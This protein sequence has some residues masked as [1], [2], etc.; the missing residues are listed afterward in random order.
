MAIW[1]DVDNRFRR[2]PSGDIR[3]VEDVDAVANSVENILLTRKG[4]R[5]MR[6]DVGSRLEQYLFEPLSEQTAYLIGVEI[7]D[8]LKQEPRVEVQNV[9]VE[10]DVRNNAYKVEITVYIKQLDVV[11][12]IERI[13][14]RI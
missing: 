13:L 6:P 2:T 10:V 7:I 12:K 5:V 9:R 8:A 1:S 11:K 4:E 14:V 3:V